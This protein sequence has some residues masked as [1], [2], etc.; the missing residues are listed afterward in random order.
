[1][2]AQLDET[3]QDILGT[4]EL[5]IITEGVDD[6]VLLIGQM[7]KMGLVEILNKHLPKHWKQRDLSWG[8]T[9]VIWL[10]YIS[11]YGDHRKVS[12]KT[13]LKVC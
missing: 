6:I 9:A 4:D 1:M 13:I 10:A 12:M 8:W 7:E 3:L 11:R 5:I 2:R